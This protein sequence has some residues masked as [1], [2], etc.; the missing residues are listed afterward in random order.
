MK[1]TLTIGILFGLLA[2]L[3]LAF[4]SSGGGGG[5]SRNAAHADNIDNGGGTNVVLNGRFNCVQDD[6]LFFK[7]LDDAL[8]ASEN[9]YPGP[10]FNRLT[11]PQLS[12]YH[13][14]VSNEP[15]Y[16]VGGDTNSAHVLFHGRY[17]GN[18]RWIRFDADIFSI[19]ASPNLFGD[20]MGSSS[21][22]AN[23]SVLHLP[24]V[25]T[26]PV[27]EQLLR[28]D[29]SGLTN[30]P[31]SAAPPAEMILGTV[32]NSDYDLTTTNGA[33]L[34]LDNINSGTQTKFIFAQNGVPFGGLR[35]GYDGSFSFHATST[36]GFQFNQTLDGTDAHGRAITEAG[37]VYSLGGPFRQASFPFELLDSGD[38][39]IFHVETD[40]TIFSPGF[41]DGLTTNISVLVSLG[42]LTKTLN[43]TNGIL[44][45]VH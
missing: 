8:G 19:L 22:F 18:E 39:S 44:K 30:L 10:V 3:S 23:V 35:G 2:S 25:P 26:T 21:A 17:A 27:M 45:G 13:L 5:T 38:E 33:A 41:T 34:V 31:S 14:V 6:G 29:G 28:H 36:A 12:Y 37:F 16:Y 7:V 32:D 40:G 24:A 1:K 4:I 43:F 15:A 9:Y 11:G 20:W 42:G